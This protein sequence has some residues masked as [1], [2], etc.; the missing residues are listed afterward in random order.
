MEELYTCHCVRYKIFAREKK[1]KDSTSNHNLSG[2]SVPLERTSITKA[3][4]R[5]KVIIFSATIVLRKKKQAATGKHVSRNNI[6]SSLIEYIYWPVKSLYWVNSKKY[7]TRWNRSAISMYSISPTHSYESF[8]RI[9]RNCQFSNEMSPNYQTP[10]NP[11]NHAIDILYNSFDNCME[12][13]FSLATR[14]KPIWLRV[15]PPHQDHHRQLTN[16]KND[17]NEWLSAKVSWC[18]I[19]HSRN[20]PNKNGGQKLNGRTPLDR[21]ERKSLNWIN[22]CQLASLDYYFFSAGGCRGGGGDVGAVVLLPV[23]ML[24]MCYFDMVSML[25]TNIHS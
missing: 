17:N 22:I 9:Y 7:H 21:N 4:T 11:S 18:M 8:A 19:P 24:E 5:W 10:V 15:W 13:G 2:S 23:T 1:L 14:P 12:P 25:Y 6:L 16:T 3:R 20:R